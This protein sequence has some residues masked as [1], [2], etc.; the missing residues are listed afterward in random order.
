AL[1]FAAVLGLSPPPALAL[2]G[3]L[4]LA[5]TVKNPRPELGAKVS[6]PLLKG[7][8]V[9]LG[10]GMDPVETLR[11]GAESAVASV[12][13]ITATLACGFLLGRSLGVG[14][15]TSALISSGTAI[16]GGSA[17]A[18]VAVTL[19]AASGEVAIALGT[20]FV[21]NAAALYLFPSIGELLSLSGETFGFW[22]GMAIHDL[23]SVVGASAQYGE[24]ALQVATA[25]KL[26]RTLYIV[27]VCFIALW[28]FQRQSS[29][30]G[31]RKPAM[32]W[33]VFVLFFLAAS[34]SRAFI[35]AVEGLAPTL[36]TVARA[37][38]TAALFVIGA[39]LT[40][41]NLRSLGWRPLAQGALLWLLISVTSLAVLSLGL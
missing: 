20:V 11:L 26:S 16:C 3:G 22:A 25:V 32:K 10:F 23:S 35:P 36:T 18:A 6:G 12:F 34:V 15:R 28:W 31:D 37:G 17:I 24:Q 19:G 29:E 39:G 14:P 8:V 2:T 38:L 5:L 40:P 7:S 33:P 1:C 4:V 41:D 21:L 13:T 30:L 27:P 9:L